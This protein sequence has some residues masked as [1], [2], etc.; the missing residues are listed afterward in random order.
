MGNILNLAKHACV[1]LT[2]HTTT[3]SPV[4]NRRKLLLEC[5]DL[6]SLPSSMCLRENSLFLTLRAE[7]LE[8]RLALMWDKHH[9]NRYVLIGLNPVGWHQ[10]CFEQLGP[11]CGERRNRLE[12][13]KMLRASVENEGEKTHLSAPHEQANRGVQPGVISLIV[14]VVVVADDPVS[15]IGFHQNRPLIA[16]GSANGCV[17]LFSLR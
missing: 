4:K 15:S 12:D 16:F 3:P 6:V 5:C 9:D 7:I 10:P 17:H 1:E 8:A 2:T 13:E 11:G 14:V